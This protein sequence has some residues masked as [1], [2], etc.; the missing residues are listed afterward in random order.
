MPVFPGAT[1]V[2]RILV[3]H[4][5]E[6][7]EISALNPKVSLPAVYSTCCSTP[8]SS[9]C[10]F[11][12]SAPSFKLSEIFPH[13]SS[14][15][16]TLVA[17][18]FLVYSQH[19]FRCPVWLLV[20]LY[21]HLE[22]YN[23]KMTRPTFDCVNMRNCHTLAYRCDRQSQILPTYGTPLDTEAPKIR[24][25]VWSSA[26]QTSKMKILAMLQRLLLSMTHEINIIPMHTAHMC[27]MVD[28]KRQQ[29][30]QI[31]NLFKNKAV[32]MSLDNISFKRHHPT[33]D[34]TGG[35]D[36]SK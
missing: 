6:M 3:L 31:K 19:L 18:I 10:F 30:T 17:I 15:I 36:S 8:F 22:Q 33:P 7:S 35:V 29:K 5:L 21:D 20:H 11:V 16:S 12:S 23:Q 14:A 32:K 9:D 2:D 28:T 27:A 13:I 4:V 24:G 25:T 34:T 1:T 26:G